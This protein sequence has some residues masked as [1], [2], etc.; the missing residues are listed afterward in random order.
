MKREMING[1]E[2]VILSRRNLT[3]LLA[4]LDGHPPDSACTIG[5][6]DDAPGLFVKAEEDDVHYASRVVPV[7]TAKYGPMH[8]S[9][10]TAAG[11]YGN[12]SSGKTLHD[13]YRGLQALALVERGTKAVW[14]EA[15]VDGH[16]LYM[17]DTSFGDGPIFRYDKHSWQVFGFDEQET[18]LTITRDTSDDD[19]KEAL[20]VARR[21]TWR[22]RFGSLL[23]ESG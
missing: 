18:P 9:T 10:E 5:G 8:P 11:M 13:L 12:V 23:G 1:T 2:W 17:T 6:G 20:E 14:H 15:D 16:H 3:S 22:S 7:G 19:L 21:A 4:K